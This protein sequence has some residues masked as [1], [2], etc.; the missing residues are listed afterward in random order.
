MEWD[1]LTIEAQKHHVPTH[2]LF[3]EQFQKAVRYG[4]AEQHAFSHLVFQGGTALRLCYQN[5][6]F[7][8]DL[9]FVMRQPHGRLDHS[10]VAVDGLVEQLQNVFPWARDL[11]TKIQKS[12]PTLSRAILSGRL[13]DTPSFRV[14]LEFANV[15]AHDVATPSLD[16]PQGAFSLAVESPQEIFADKVVA[17]GLR[18]YI[19]G[20]DV[21][22]I[23]FLQS[24]KILLPVELI[25][26]KL[27]DYGASAS[28][29]QTN[30]EQRVALLQSSETQSQLRDELMRFLR[31]DQVS[32]TDEQNAWVGMAQSSARLLNSIRMNPVLPRPGGPL[33]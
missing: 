15:P 18:P 7:S 22:D 20:R 13:P 12:T 33:L 9:E 25:P 30:L 16:A 27:Q 5:P 6:R 4:M 24:Q 26:R 3:R 32:S 23:A 21:W 10:G 19:K 31:P 11:T 14:H 17:L 28:V 2:W 1:Q 8:E 29:F